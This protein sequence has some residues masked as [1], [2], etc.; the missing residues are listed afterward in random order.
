MSSI[1][2]LVRVI[3]TVVGVGGWLDVLHA[4]LN[5]MLHFFKISDPVL[6][7]GESSINNDQACED[8]SD[9]EVD[10]EYVQHYGLN[11]GSS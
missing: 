5:I 3:R 2:V 1:F 10:P 4:C 11:F 7:H 8:N 6:N 9:S